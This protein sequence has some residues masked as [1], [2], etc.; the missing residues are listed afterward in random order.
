MP[1]RTRIVE[2]LSAKFEHNGLYKEKYGNNIFLASLFTSDVK[3]ALR[4][5]YRKSIPYPHLSISSACDDIRLRCV[6]KE[7]KDRMN[8]T[9]K[10]TDLFKVYQTT[11]LAGLLSDAMKKQTPELL[12][13]RSSIYSSEFR[14]LISIISG[15]G[16]LSDRVDC[17]CNIYCQG[18]HL[19]CH[20]DVI[21]SRAVSFILYLSDPENPWAKSDGG[22]LE[23]Y[24][25]EENSPSPRMYHSKAILPTWNKFLF[26]EVKPGKS[27]H[28]IQE[29]FVD[30]KPRVSIS[31]WF[32]FLDTNIITKYASREQ[33]SNTAAYK[34][35]ETSHKIP[36]A[37]HELTSKF[38]LSK[39]D[40]LFLS[41]WVSA[42]YLNRANIIA[43]RKNFRMEK[44]VQ[45]RDFLKPELSK[46]IDDLLFGK[47]RQRTSNL[48]ANKRDSRNWKVVGPPH[49][50]R[51]LKLENNEKYYRNDVE[52]CALASS[53]EA[54]VFKSDA[55]NR[56]L[57]AVT[58]Q[59][60]YESKSTIRNFRRGLDYTLAHKNLNLNIPQLHSTLCFV[61]SD[62]LIERQ[63]WASGNCGGF[64]CFIPTLPELKET[65]A[66][67]EVYDNN[68]NEKEMISVHASFNTLSLIKNK[69]HD[70]YFL[71]YLSKLAPSDRYD[72]HFCYSV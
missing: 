40:I 13:L 16:K 54:N 57:F 69:G 4:Q 15:C 33:L 51:Y 23:L 17:S 22:A 25:I 19:L 70:L 2:P 72:I 46:K 11:D 5:K 61:K 8:A 1:K 12:A 65:L 48:E 71:K 24:D 34:K 49:M 31:G 20:D 29:V 9:F 68:S 26:F 55:Y 27:F 66:C 3:E 41:N 14:E 18:G 53:L 32:H 43:I 37:V 39:R 45:L 59:A 10:E 67:A 30:N 38:E 21:G 60:A 35:R 50:Q 58:D 62:S 28:A 63:S 47:M 42:E 64:E 44:C 52:F 36:R 56:W 6:L 7:V